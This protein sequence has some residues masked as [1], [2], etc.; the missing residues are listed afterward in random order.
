[1]F[2]GIRIGRPSLTVIAPTAQVGLEL[3]SPSHIRHSRP[4]IIPRQTVISTLC[5]RHWEPHQ[6]SVWRLVG[7]GILEVLAILCQVV[8]RAPDVDFLARPMPDSTFH[9]MSCQASCFCQ[10]F[11]FFFQIE[12]KTRGHFDMNK[13]KTCNDSLPNCPRRPH[14]RGSLIPAPPLSLLPPPLPPLCH[15]PLCRSHR[16][17][18]RWSCS[19]GSGRGA[20]ARPSLRRCAVIARLTCAV[21]AHRCTVITSRHRSSLWQWSSCGSCF[22][23]PRRGCV[24]EWDSQAVVVVLVLQCEATCGSGVGAM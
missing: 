1:M 18:R 24:I 13:W 3:V 21:V 23:T 5:G 19:R 7:L 8:S 6:H 2:I 11:D 20:I 15:R 22:N 17:G 16:G 4:F 12:A 9:Q 10:T 14:S